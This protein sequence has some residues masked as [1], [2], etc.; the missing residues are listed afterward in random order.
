MG[1]VFLDL[2]WGGFLPFPETTIVPSGPDWFC[3]R[4]ISSLIFISPFRFLS[5]FLI[6]SVMFWFHVPEHPAVVRQE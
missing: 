4:L 5:P 3:S 1:L 6:F 2:I